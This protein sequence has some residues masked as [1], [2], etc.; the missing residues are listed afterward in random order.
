VGND[1]GVCATEKNPGSLNVERRPPSISVGAPT[2]D[3][4]AHPEAALPADS[5]AIAGGDGVDGVG[6]VVETELEVA[7]EAT[8]AGDFVDVLA[9]FTVVLIDG[10]G[11]RLPVA[12]LDGFDAFAVGGLP[13]DLLAAFASD[14]G[15]QLD[16]TT[17]VSAAHAAMSAPCPTG[18]DLA[19]RSASSTIPISHTIVVPT[20]ETFGSLPTKTERFSWIAPNVSR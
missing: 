14:E 6:G 3:Q 15:T 4:V 5:R 11:R 17:A 20:K 10:F 9:A 13:P 1:S 12:P 7:L 8:V 18:L 2:D 16:S 19:F